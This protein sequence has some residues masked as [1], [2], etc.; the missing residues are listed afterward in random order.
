M[1][2]TTP[3]VLWQPS[4]ERIENATLTRF[5]RWLGKG[6]LSYGELWQWSVDDVEAFW[7][8]VWEFFDVQA[9]EP[10]ERV[11]GSRSMPGAEWFVGARLNYAEHIFR[12]KDPE[13]IAIRATSEDAPLVEV[14]WAQLRALTARVAAA[15]GL[16]I[17]WAR[18]AASVPSE[19]R[20]S[21]RR[22]CSRPSRRRAM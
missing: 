9:S 16:L 6:D 14:T 7:A 22:T 1:A 8:A 12:G 18:P 4:A 3:P 10:Y 13:T 21:A 5:A 2:A 20:R 11:L 15:A 19:P 17:S